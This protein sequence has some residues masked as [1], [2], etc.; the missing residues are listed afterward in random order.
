MEKNTS[1]RTFRSSLRNTKFR[2][3]SFERASWA[4]YGAVCGVDE[5]G[6][7]CLAGP[8]VTAAVILPIGK[9]PR[10][11]KDSKLMTAEQ[12]LIGYEWI[13][14]HC[15]YS[16]G[17]IHHRLIDRVNIWHATLMAM[18]RA[19]IQL[20]S[21]CPI[22]PEHILIDAM[23]LNLR[24]TCYRS[25]PI[26]YFPFGETKSSSIA[27]ASII[28]KVK[29]DAIMK[30]TDLIIPG[31]SLKNHKG[32]STPK[33]KVAIRNIG[34]SIIHRLSYLKR[35]RLLEKDNEGNE[36]KSIC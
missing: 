6:R 24:N 18:K 11:L 31:Y 2:K 15:W 9:A 7:G 1:K 30:R 8:V 23:P 21:H 12:R 19:V 32:Y 14:K 16:Y 28:A 26:D 10:I 22:K 17:I 13:T 33:H 3:N 20:L 5:V 25:I 27:A 29:R 4:K 36:Q 35:L 34:R